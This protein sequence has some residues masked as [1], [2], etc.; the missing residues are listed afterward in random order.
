MRPDVSR[1][2]FIHILLSKLSN[3]ITTVKMSHTNS[4]SFKLTLSR[5]MF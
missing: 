4:D 1:G 5:N 2:T 3:K